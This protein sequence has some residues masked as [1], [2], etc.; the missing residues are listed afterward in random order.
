MQSV[1]AAV[2]ASA[3]IRELA[4]IAYKVTESHTL[5]LSVA[6]FTTDPTTIPK[7][8]KLGLLL[9]EVRSLSRELQSIKLKVERIV[10]DAGTAASTVC[11]SEEVSLGRPGA[12]SRYQ[13]LNRRSSSPDVEETSI[14]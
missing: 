5:P 11:S 2:P 13:I 1:L 8:D 3:T 9:G 10:A 7:D 14:S 4:E 6:S 12:R